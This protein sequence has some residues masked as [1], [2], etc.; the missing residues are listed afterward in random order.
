VFLCKVWGSPAMGAGPE[1]KEFR[2]KV[3]TDGK[4]PEFP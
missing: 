1:R 3:R 4:L 2:A